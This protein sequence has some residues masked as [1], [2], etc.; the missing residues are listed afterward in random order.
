[1]ADKKKQGK[2][3]W[4]LWLVFILYVVELLWFFYS[5]FISKIVNGQPIDFE[6][7]ELAVILVIGLLAII[8][9]FVLKKSKKVGGILISVLIGSVFLFG[10]LAPLLDVYIP[11]IWKIFSGF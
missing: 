9:F 3:K 6:S 8:I 10:V 5:Q 2:S 11:V 4:A 7:K 1:M